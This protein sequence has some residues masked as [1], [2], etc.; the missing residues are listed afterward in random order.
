MKPGLITIALAALAIVAFAVPD[1]RGATGR[2]VSLSLAGGNFITST[3]D[4][5]PTPLDG[6]PLTALQSGL[7]KGPGQPLFVAQTVLSEI[8]QDPTMFPPACLAQ[9]LAGAPLSTTVV[10][11]YSDG[12]VLSLAT[13]A[14]SYFCTDGTTFTVS[15]GGNVTGGEGRFAGATGTWEGTASSVSARVLAEVRIDLAD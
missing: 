2:D 14:G 11:T 8:P 7:A 6:Q 4:G 10:F 15:F 1:A 3:V 12:S 13:D 5:T 9:G